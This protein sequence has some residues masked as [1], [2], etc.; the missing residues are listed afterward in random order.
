[1]TIKTR[2]TFVI[3]AEAAV[4]STVLS[5]AVVLSPWPH[6]SPNG[7]RVVLLLAFFAPFFLA[8]WWIFRRLKSDYSRSDS[9]RGAL[10]FAVTAPLVLG[11]GNLLGELVG[12][13]V[14]V[15]LGSRFI[16]PSIGAL[17]IVLMIFLPAGVVLWALHPSAGVEA[18]SEG[19]QHEHC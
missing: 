11:V 5:Y 13:Y 1:M 16:L 12:G 15:L 2:S 10:A 18:V 3:V 17:V 14:E 9:R 8:A 4:V 6:V 19:N 7:A